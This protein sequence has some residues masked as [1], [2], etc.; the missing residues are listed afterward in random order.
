M[1]ICIYI[2]AVFLITLGIYLIRGKNGTMRLI[3]REVVL[4]GKRVGNKIELYSKK[5]KFR[6]WLRKRKGERV[7]REVYDSISFLRNII[8]SGNGRRVGSDYIIEQLSHR[9]GA[10]RP[11]FIR[12]LSF[13]RLGKIDD[14]VKAFTGEA[15]TPIGLEFGDLLLKWDGVDPLE[16]T[17]ILIS[18]QKSI[19]EVKSTAQRKRDEITSELIYFPVVLNVFVIFINFIVVGY[20]MEQQQMFRMMF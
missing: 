17:E 1:Q 15:F 8:A 5:I 12:M 2:S 7:D 10:L 18:Y 13:L 20:F 9:E 11:V 3:S 6:E 16:L 14:A 4:S 19:R